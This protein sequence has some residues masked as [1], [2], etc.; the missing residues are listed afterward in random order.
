MV[1]R[2]RRTLVGPPVSPS[3]AATRPLERR[4]GFGSPAGLGSSRSVA[5][6]A[7]D[8]LALEEGLRRV[9]RRGGG[10][11]SPS[12]STSGSEAA[13]SRA[14][15]AAEVPSRCWSGSARSGGRPPSAGCCE[16]A[17]DPRPPLRPR[18]LRLGE[19]RAFGWV[20]SVASGA[21]SAGEALGPVVAF[22]SSEVASSAGAAAG[23][24]PLWLRPRPRPPRR[25]L[26]RLVA[27]A[28]CWP[29]AGSVA[30]EERGSLE[31]SG[32]A[33]PFGATGLWGS[34][35]MCGSPFFLGEPVGGRAHGRPGPVEGR[36]ANDTG[37][38]RRPLPACGVGHARRPLHR[39]PRGSGG[40]TP[41]PG[42]GRP[43]GRRGTVPSHRPA[44][45]PGGETPSIMD[46]APRGGGPVSRVL[47]N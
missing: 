25:R 6:A 46:P 7:F 29:S 28:D 37:R 36:G 19:G 35:G 5:G 33:C 21:S 20:T 31:G 8:P 24:D 11:A 41:K 17:P 22:G 14:T 23:P 45:R 30:T 16:P 43:T 26:L 42:P 9:R 15:G 2:G 27:G 4:A 1:V 3:D 18:R 10:A 39:A 40:R 34:S 13:S 32:S 44:L 47:G 12:V 38:M